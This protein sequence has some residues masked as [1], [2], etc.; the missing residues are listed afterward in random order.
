MARKSKMNPEERR[1]YTAQMRA[2]LEAVMDRAYGAMTAGEE[3]WSEVMRTAAALPDRSPV[4]VIAIAAQCPGAT[5]VH[6]VSDWRK[7]GRY[8]AKGSTSIRIWTPIRRRPDAPADTVAGA[9]QGVGEAPGS[10]AD[11]NS[12]AVSGYKAAPVFD[13][14][15]TGGDDYRHPAPLLTPAAAVRDTLVIQYRQA[16]G[17]DPEAEGGFDFSGHAP[18]DAAR[19]LLYGHALRRIAEADVL[20]RGQRPAE[21]ASAAHVAALILGITPGPAVMPPLAGIIT[22]D[23][24]PPVHGAAVRVIE[25]GR[26]IAEAVKASHQSVPAAAPG[27]LALR[28]CPTP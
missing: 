7:A 25:T 9:A 13:I 19:I 6:G 15:Q 10:P 21:V 3:F 16:Y 14:S 27:D 5:R 24:K 17:E 28:G 1:A 12:R 23:R 26:A 22:G 20:V 4:N 11:S 2:E 18:D 8:P